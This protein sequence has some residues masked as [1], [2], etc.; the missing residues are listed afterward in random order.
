MLFSDSFAQDPKQ[1]GEESLVKEV[2]R[3]PSLA[4]P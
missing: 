1:T 2:L 4:P 3:E